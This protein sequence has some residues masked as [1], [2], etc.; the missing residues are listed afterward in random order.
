[1][2]LCAIVAALIS[3]SPS[4]APRLHAWLYARAYDARYLQA[5][6]LPGGNQPNE[7]DENAFAILHA[8]YDLGAGFSAG[9]TYMFSDPNALAGLSDLNQIPE[10]YLAYE[11]KD[12]SIKAGNQYFSS[13]WADTHF[14][15]GLAP[16]AFQGVDALYTRDAWT[17]EAAG[18]TRFMSRTSSA[19]NRTNL[20]TGVAD[21]VDTSGFTYGRVTYA[22]PDARFSLSGY[23]YNVDDMVA[24]GWFSGITSLSAHGWQPFAGA[25]GG[26]EANAGASY[27]GIV[28]SSIAGL[29]VGA[30]PTRNITLSAAFDEIPWRRTTLA[31]G[32]G[33]SCDSAGP[34][35]T[36]QIENAN[37]TFPYLLPQGVAQCT[38]NGNGSTTLYY[39]GWASPYSDGYATDPMYTSPLLEGTVDRRS[40]GTSQALIGLYTSN[41]RRLTFTESYYWFDYSN[42]LATQATTEWDNVLAYYFSEVK[43]GR[44][45]GLLFR[46]GYVQQHKSNVAYAG[47]DGFLGGVPL[48]RYSRFQLE[49]AL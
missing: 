24:L 34:A 15:L 33:A 20:L 6:S 35:P 47:G 28:R 29:I 48:T 16:T 2:L 26:I 7:T 8:D 14:K 10:S 22:P 27:L 45:R 11:A 23:A 43:S 12:L 9:G 21:G 40:P 36:Y 38:N 5:S 25:Q 49:Y 44:Y 1:M 37:A 19:F 3:P 30:T 39:G 13:P 32:K 31:L 17:F 41:D 42:P 4:P 18:I 46:Y